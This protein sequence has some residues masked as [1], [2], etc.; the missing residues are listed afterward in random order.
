[1]AKFQGGVDGIIKALQ[2]MNSEE[3]DRLLSEVSKKDP[4]MA[5]LINEKLYSL[6][7][8]EFISDKM[9]VE[10]LQKVNSKHLGFAFK[11]QNDD[12][13]N[14]FIKRVPRSIR[15]DIL[16]SRNESKIAKRDALSYEKEILSLFR[17][18]I[19]KGSLVLSKNDD[20]I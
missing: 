14:E 4:R 16:Y 8:L 13:V 12:F 17:D 9:L 5:E 20:Y 3:R 15:E 19:D 2:L 7:D 11:L 1:M 6:S 10:F 18:M